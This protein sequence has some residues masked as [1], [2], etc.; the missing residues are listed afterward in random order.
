MQA[1]LQDIASIITGL[2]ISGRSPTGKGDQIVRFINVSDLMNGAIISNSLKEETVEDLAKVKRYQVKAGDILVT[3]RG[4]GFKTAIVPACLEGCVISANLV[5]IRLK[6]NAP[7]SPDV[8]R[9]YL[10]SKVGW[11][12]ID[13]R[14]QGSVITHLSTKDLVGLPVPI[15]E[16]SVQAKL[17]NLSQVSAKYFEA[18]QSL[19]ETQHR[20]VEEAI[21]QAFTAKEMVS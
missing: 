12:E 11:A 19:I 2:S 8:L 10:E 6:A 18:T 13:Q 17:V 9:I 5:A 20:L 3:V 1:P 15:P 7:I 14:R 21:A 16:L 4:A